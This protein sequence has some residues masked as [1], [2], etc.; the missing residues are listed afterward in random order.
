[1]NRAQP[2]G[3]ILKKDSGRK[4]QQQTRKHKGGTR[5]TCPTLMMT[6][7]THHKIILN[8]YLKKINLMELQMF[9]LLLNCWTFTIQR[10][11]SYMGLNTL[12]PY[13]SMMF[14]KS[15]LWIRWLQLIRQYITHLVLEYITNLILYSNQNHMSFE[16]NTMALNWK[17]SKVVSYIQGKK[18]W[19]RIYVL[20]K[21]FSPCFRVLRL[22]DRNKSGTDK[23]F[24][25]SRI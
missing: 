17:L 5:Y 25:Y 8:C 13:F 18:G 19:Y 14:T 2:A 12:Y 1:M 10:F 7:Q 21:I 16:F 6:E 20:L 23:V 24:Y 22:A 4:P 15:Q 3:T 9:S 11:H